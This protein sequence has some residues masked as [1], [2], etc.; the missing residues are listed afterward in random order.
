MMKSEKK[1]KYEKKPKSEKKSKSPS[2]NIDTYDLP[3]FSS[4]KTKN[5][6][7]SDDRLKL[8][9]KIEEMLALVKLE[10]FEVTNDGIFKRADKLISELSKMAVVDRALMTR[11]INLLGEDDI[12]NADDYEQLEK[13]LKNSDT[14]LYFKDCELIGKVNNKTDDFVKVCINIGMQPKIYNEGKNM[15]E[16]VR[17]KQPQKITIISSHQLAEKHELV[18]EYICEYME[19]YGCKI[20]S[21]NIKCF[22][23]E[24]LNKFEILITKYFVTNAKEKDE[25]IAGLRK[26]I[27]NKKGDKTVLKYLG[28]ED[29]DDF[30]FG[31]SS[32]I[33][34]PYQKK[35]MD[36][37]DVA[38]TSY[39]G[40][41][42][43]IVGAVRSCKELKMGAKGPIIIN[44]NGPVNNTNIV[45]STISGDGHNIGVMTNNISIYD[46]LIIDLI[47]QKPNW[48]NTNKYLSKKDLFKKFSAMINDDVSNNVFWQKL[49]NRLVLKEKQAWNKGNREQQIKLKPLW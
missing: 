20:G 46:K 24:D 33:M 8:I 11:V 44:I 29:T 1:S 5:N 16:I 42:E 39:K 2:K 22:K 4:T 18:K 47:A 35:N 10:T 41:E 37:S 14:I 25:F 45:N 31:D 12:Y 15:Y 48:Y 34:M 28:K 38:L 23:N 9:G 49:K 7:I 3:Q 13:D 6:E 36:G 40:V 26:F 43:L 19:E 21:K 30:D 17:D 32:T 27:K